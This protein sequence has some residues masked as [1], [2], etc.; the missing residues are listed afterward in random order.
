MYHGLVFG[1]V[2][3]IHDPLSRRGRAAIMGGV[4]ALLVGL[5]AGLFGWLAPDPDPG[6]SALWR[7][8]G[9]QIYVHLDGVAYP[10]P[11][12]TSAHLITGDASQPARVGTSVLAHTPVG[13]PL[14]L[15]RVPYSF[16]G[17]TSSTAPVW[18]VCHDG[19]RVVVSADNRPDPWP[20]GAG[21]LA[22]SGAEEYLIDA[23]GRTL[24]PPAESIEGRAV[25]RA[26]NITA[27][28]PRWQA[29][30]GMLSAVR[31]RPDTRIP[32]GQVVDTGADLW[33]VDDRSATHLTET[34]ARAIEWTGRPRRVGNVNEIAHLEQ[35]ADLVYL[36]AHDVEFVDPS[37]RRGVG[38]GEPGDAPAVCVVDRGLALSQDV[39]PG[40]RLVGESEAT[41][42]VAPGL[43]GAAIVDTGFG[44]VGVSSS[45]VRHEFVSAGDVALVGGEPV[46]GPREI[47]TLLPEGT[48]LDAEQARRGVLGD[49]AEASG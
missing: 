13:P 26:L 20:E 11:N 18:S 23:T 45:G 37:P 32:E 33:L 19:Q 25:R 15:S 38:A 29:P 24:L 7:G 1:D 41:H 14:G 44:F 48:K 43:V 5:G 8:P 40:V 31:Q 21:L 17:F 4:S 6:D 16:E 3:M 42:F 9:D 12:L 30:A 47:I 27:A 49:A 2:R 22:V 36:P 10:V 46:P 34:Q 39:P 28:T 35:R